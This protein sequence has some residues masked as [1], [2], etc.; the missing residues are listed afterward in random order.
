MT[1]H[2]PAGWSAAARSL[3]WI[4]AAMIFSLLAYG[5]W[6]THLAERGARIGHY[7]LHA[8]IGVYFVLLLALRLAWRAI[9]HAPAAPAAKPWARVAARA[10][11]L[12]LYLLMIGVAATG[13]VMWS[14]FPRRVEV[15]VLGLTVPFVFAAPDRAISQLAEGVHK[16]LAYALLA[17]V[18]LHIAAALRH[19]FVA[20]DDVLR[21]M[22]VGTRPEAARH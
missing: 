3:H 21:R 11:H 20:R 9:D 15:D 4:G 8:T 19:H 10:A 14:A 12:G 17:L 22:T 5:W 7:H 2:E 1:R 13:W 6:M 16:F 18:V